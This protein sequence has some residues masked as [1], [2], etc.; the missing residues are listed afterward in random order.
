MVEAAGSL[1]EADALSVVFSDGHLVDAAEGFRC[2]GGLSSLRGDVG[3]TCL[4]VEALAFFCSLCSGTFS[5]LRSFV[6]KLM[7]GISFIFLKPSS[8][9]ESHGKVSLTLYRQR[10]REREIK[11]FYEEHPRSSTVINSSALWWS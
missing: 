6:N 1:V 2:Y 11:F 7:A 9:G 10:E 3:S 4:E 5:A 8:T